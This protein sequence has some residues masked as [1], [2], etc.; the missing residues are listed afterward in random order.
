MRDPARE[1]A[2]AFQ[3]LSL[4]QPRP[5][6]VFWRFLVFAAPGAGFDRAPLVEFAA[7]GGRIDHVKSSPVAQKALRRGGP[8]CERASIITKGDD[9]TRL[10]VTNHSPQQ[11]HPPHTT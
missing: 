9:I 7:F 8:P 5:L 10:V 2:E 3:A 6:S 4:L 11:T 1:L